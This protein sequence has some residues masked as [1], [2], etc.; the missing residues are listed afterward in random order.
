MKCPK[1]KSKEIDFIE[2][3]NGF[4][5]TWSYPDYTKAEFEMG[6]YSHIECECN[7]CGHY[8]KPRNQDT[9]LIEKHKNEI[10]NEH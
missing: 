5:G 9:D 8:W 6:I 10:N 2:I 1:C 7:K 3:S 4:T